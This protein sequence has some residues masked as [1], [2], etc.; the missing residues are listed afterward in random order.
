MRRTVLAR[1]DV[2]RRAVAARRL[3]GAILLAQ[4]RRAVDMI[5]V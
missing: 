1:P 4:V 5:G 3:P 2:L